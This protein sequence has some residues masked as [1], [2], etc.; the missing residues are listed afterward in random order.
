[1]EL[2]LSSGR[3]NR[4]RGQVTRIP[5]EV[6]PGRAVARTRIVSAVSSTPPTFSMDTGSRI[7]GALSA[8]V[9][10]AHTMSGFGSIG[11]TCHSRPLLACWVSVSAPSAQAAPYS[12]LG[13]L[14]RWPGGRD[15][16]TRM[17]SRAVAFVRAIGNVATLR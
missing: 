16:E 2:N 17:R 10:S 15:C 1:M 8:A 6:D 5:E 4:S 11:R 9:A 3:L 13:R 14:K 12:A 7:H